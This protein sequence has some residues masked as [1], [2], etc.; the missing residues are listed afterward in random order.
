M[1]SKRARGKLYL[2]LLQYIQLFRSTA[3]GQGVA[4]PPVTQRVRVRSPVGTRSLGEV[5]SV[6]SLTCKTNVR[7]FQTHK[8]P[9]YHLV[10]ITS[11]T[12]HYGRQWPEMLT[13]QKT[14]NIHT[15]CY[16]A[17]NCVQISV[18]INL[19]GVFRGFHSVFKVNAGL[20]C[21]CHDQFDH[22]SLIIL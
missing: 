1:Y 6:F 8:V 12:P 4:C 3:V 9:E 5:F 14:S 2:S 17:W 15:Y 18:P 20:D 22:Y 11:S 16:P 7:K 13:R 19:I 10:I 21:H